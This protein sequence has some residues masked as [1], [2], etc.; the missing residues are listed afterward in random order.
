MSKNQYNKIIKNLFLIGKFKYKHKTLDHMI[1][2]SK[3]LGNPHKNL[4]CIHIAGTNGK[5]SLCFE[6]AQKLNMRGYK[7]GLFTS[8]HILSFRERIRIN[9]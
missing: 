1:H 4:K 8:P 3:L 7:V 2:A 6:L 5:S 9:Q